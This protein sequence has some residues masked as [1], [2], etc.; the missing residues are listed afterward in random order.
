MKF[1]KTIMI[2]VFAGAAAIIAGGCAFFAHSHYKNIE[3]PV[4]PMDTVRLASL[5]SVKNR[6]DIVLCA[7]RG[8]SAEYPENTVV[9]VENAILNGYSYVEFDVHESLDGTLMVMSDPT[10]NRMTN[11]RGRISSKSYKDLLTLTVD[12]GANIEKFDDIRIPALG[13]MLNKCIGSVPVINIRDISK[14]GIDVLFTVLE[15]HDLLRNSVVA[16]KDKKKLL[17]FRSKSTE[18]E[19]WYFVDKITSDAV[20]FCMENTNIKLSFNANNLFNTGR[21]VSKTLEKGVEMNCYV[22]NDADVLKKYAA[23]GVT[24][25]ITDA[26]IPMA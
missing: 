25:F 10:L 5:T 16:S 12:N 23:A 15:K 8:F 2:F 24:E 11:G 19:L 1:K 17:Y 4:K 14:D 13:T 6:E 7:H 18:T 26:I 22:V 3:A 20:D 21:L 9:A